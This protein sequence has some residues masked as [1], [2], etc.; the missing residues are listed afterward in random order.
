M[1]SSQ[2][3]LLSIFW[4]LANSLQGLAATSVLFVSWPEA[5]RAHQASSLFAASAASF[6]LACREPGLPAHELLYPLSLIARSAF[7]AT[8]SAPFSRWCLVLLKHHFPP[9]TGRSH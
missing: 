6:L 8:L 1:R 3:V 5:A 7:P 2:T 9:C 4:F